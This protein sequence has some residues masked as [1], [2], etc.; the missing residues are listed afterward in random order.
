MNFKDEFQIIFAFRVLVS[1]PLRKLILQLKNGNAPQRPAGIPKL[2]KH[3]NLFK[4]ILCIWSEAVSLNK[5]SSW[6]SRL[7]SELI[8]IVGKFV[9]LFEY[10]K[11]L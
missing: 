4:F 6:D 11:L 9:L 2:T 3:V 1:G 5:A 10:S 7:S 8:A